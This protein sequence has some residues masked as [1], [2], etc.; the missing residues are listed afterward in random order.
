M[1]QRSAI[2]SL[3]QPNA[4]GGLHTVEE[5]IGCIFRRSAGGAGRPRTIIAYQ[6]EGG[7]ATVK[8]KL[9][10]E[11]DKDI[12]TGKVGSV[13]FVNFPS[14]SSEFRNVE[15]S[16]PAPTAKGNYEHFEVASVTYDGHSNFELKGT[17]SFPEVDVTAYCQ[18]SWAKKTMKAKQT[19]AF[20]F[21][22][23]IEGND[24]TVFR[25]TLD[26]GWTWNYVTTRTGE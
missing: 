2:S 11:F 16:C 3:L 10:L 13:T 9:V 7:Q 18:G 22:A 26:S 20:E 5:P 19:T 8:D 4:E 24:P 15:K 23:M 12:K 1:L 25:I 6:E 14:T 21:E 17:R